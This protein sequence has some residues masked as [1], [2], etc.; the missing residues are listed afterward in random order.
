MAEQAE[1]ELKTAGAE[2]KLVEYEGGHG[3]RGDVFGAIRDGI[4]WLEKHHAR[5]SD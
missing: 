5:P 4:L 3:W 1:K 2:V